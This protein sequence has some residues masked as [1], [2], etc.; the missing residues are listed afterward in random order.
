MSILKS[1]SDDQLNE[2]AKRST[3]EKVYRNKKIYDAGQHMDYVYLIDRGSVKLGMIAECD[4]ILIKDIVYDQG[5]FGENIFTGNKERKD[6]AEAM[7]DTVLYKV[8][9]PYFKL[10]VEANSAFAN[11]IMMTILGRLKN[12]EQRMQ[13]FVFMKAKARIVNFIK[14]TGISRG[15]KI[16]M[17]EI[18]INHGMSH[19]E[20]A[21]L[22]D[23]SRQTVARVLGELKKDELIHFSAR[24]PSKIL[25][26]NS[27]QLAY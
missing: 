4:K 1:L 2:L 18:L 15:I 7:T 6:F 14:N 26:R 20:I 12:L 13:N 19:K 23:T 10:L 16:G 11:T 27:F 22:T 17:D 8:P 21:Y 24:K 25:I 3:L 5:I 9:V